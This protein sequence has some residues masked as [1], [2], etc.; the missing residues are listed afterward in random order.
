MRE[1]YPCT[2]SHYHVSIVTNLGNVMAVRTVDDV[3][4]VAMNSNR[5]FNFD[6]IIIDGVLSTGPPPIQNLPA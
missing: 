1:V 4:E 5:A 6:T 3:L 2:A